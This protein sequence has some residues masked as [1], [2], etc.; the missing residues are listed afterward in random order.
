M[1]ISNHDI[2]KLQNLNTSYGSRKP[3]PKPPPILPLQRPPPRF[4]PTY[5]NKKRL[6]LL[7]LC[8][9]FAYLG[10]HA[11]Y[12]GNKIQ[13]SL[14]LLAGVVYPSLGFLTYGT[15]L[16]AI[17]IGF[18]LFAPLVIL[19]YVICWIGDMIRIV[20]SNYYDNDGLLIE[21]WV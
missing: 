15:G 19:I 13:G 18:G 11:F 2:Q 10:L 1:P 16:E 14:Y 7:L 12:A 17:S 5:S 9:F 4:T 3:P 6:P 8:I 21:N 20:S